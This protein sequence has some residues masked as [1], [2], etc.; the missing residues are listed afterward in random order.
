MT[1]EKAVM[2]G[3]AVWICFFE[4]KRSA[5]LSFVISIVLYKICKSCRLE[6]SGFA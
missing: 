3:Y 5:L 2:V 4:K 1:D 6:S